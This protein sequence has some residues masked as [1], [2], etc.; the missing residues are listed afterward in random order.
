MTDEALVALRDL[1]FSMYG[2]LGKYEYPIAHPAF[3]KWKAARSYALR[4]EGIL[5]V[6]GDVKGKRVLDIG[7]AEGAFSHHLALR[8]AK[9]TGLD[10]C[11][12][13]TELAEGVSRLYELPPDNPLFIAIRFERY[14]KEHAAERFDFIL[15]LSLV[16]HFLRRGLKSTWQ[17]M[18]LVS[19]HTDIM[20]LEADLT[21][22]HC[23]HLVRSGHKQ[24]QMKEVIP[25]LIVGHS[26]FRDYEE[27]PSTG[28]IRPFFVFTK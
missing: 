24:A 2:R 8:G 21:P 1:Y 11:S 6:V 9:V 5:S 3:A 10:Y 12:W 26:G 28:A 19:Q 7:C 4:L 15:F 22:L 14:L 13:R 20:F 16:H 17:K 18:E 23:R 27:L 25:R